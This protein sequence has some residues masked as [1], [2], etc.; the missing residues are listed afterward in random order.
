MENSTREQ[1]KALLKELVEDFDRS[2]KYADRVVA[3]LATEKKNRHGQ[4]IKKPVCVTKAMVYQ[5][6]S[7]T[8]YNSDVV[9]TIIVLRR[10]K[11]LSDIRENRLLTQ[12]KTNTHLCRQL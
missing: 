12:I 11:N 4:V 10:A 8:C 1:N 5:N 9:H 2:F 6:V 7:G 3:R